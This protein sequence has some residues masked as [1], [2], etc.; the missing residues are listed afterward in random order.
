L[1]QSYVV[2]VSTEHRIEPTQGTRD[3]TLDEALE[4]VKKG[5]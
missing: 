3:V 4:I 1:V 2:N 5:E